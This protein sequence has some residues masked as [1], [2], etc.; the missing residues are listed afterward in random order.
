MINNEFKD[1]LGLEETNTPEQLDTLEVQ[2]LEGMHSRWIFDLS[3]GS[4]PDITNVFWPYDTDTNKTPDSGENAQGAGSSNGRIFRYILENKVYYQNAP[5]WVGPGKPSMAAMFYR[6]H[7]TIANASENI[8]YPL[9]SYDDTPATKF[10]EPYMTDADTTINWTSLNFGEFFP[11]VDDPNEAE[12]LQRLRKATYLHQVPVINKDIA[13]QI[14]SSQ[15]HGFRSGYFEFSLKTNNQNCMV[16][17]GENGTKTPDTTTTID[18]DTVVLNKANQ[19]T[20]SMSVEI[21]NGKL[22]F[23]YTDLSVDNP[24]SFE[25]LSNKTIADNEWHH[26]VINF[27]K[28]GVLGLNRKNTSDC[29]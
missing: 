5:R 6:N 13:M 25:I 15:D 2:Y 3:D 19:D 1:I 8:Y 22:L 23:K 11:G 24:Q 21:K 27:N 12:S 14:G 9:L 20:S 17:Y 10:I 7:R 4:F 28:N 26:I 18:K 29:L 16:F